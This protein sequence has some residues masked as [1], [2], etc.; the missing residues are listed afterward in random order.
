MASMSLLQLHLGGARLGGCEHV[1]ESMWL[2]LAVKH[3]LRNLVCSVCNCSHSG[4][5]QSESTGV[6]VQCDFRCSCRCRRKC[7]HCQSLP[8][9]NVRW[10]CLKDCVVVLAVKAHTFCRRLRAS[11]ACNDDWFALVWGI[12]CWLADGRWY[13]ACMHLAGWGLGVGLGF[14]AL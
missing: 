3:A 5:L 9:A 2:G 14:L 8:V 1:R 6:S 7:K 13:M 10:V 12:C 11:R 4:C